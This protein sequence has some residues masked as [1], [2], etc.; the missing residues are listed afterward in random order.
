MRLLDAADHVVDRRRQNARSLELPAEPIERRARGQLPVEQ[1]ITRFLER[2]VLRKIVDGV[3][4][5]AQLARAAIDVT[6]A[7]SVEIDAFQTAV[8]FDLLLRFAHGI[9]PL[10]WLRGPTRGQRAPYQW[11]DN[12]LAP[13]ATRGQARL[14]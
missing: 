7:R 4:A 13:F 1:Q 2:G 3:A 8:H 9:P 11:D 14:A 10:G 12:R 5:V 6:H